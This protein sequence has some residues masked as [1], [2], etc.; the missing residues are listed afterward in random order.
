MTSC[1]RGSVLRQAAYGTPSGPGT[2]REVAAV[3]RRISEHRRRQAAVSYAMGRTAAL[4]P[5]E[6]VE[7][8]LRG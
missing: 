8:E 5:E 6:A 7:S 4:S 3:A 2:E 1:V